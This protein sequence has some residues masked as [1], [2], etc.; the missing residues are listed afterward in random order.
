[1]AQSVRIVIDSGMAH[2][3]WQNGP[4]VWEASLSKEELEVEIE[5]HAPGSLRN[6]L[7]EAQRRLATRSPAYPFAHLHA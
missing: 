4:H 2:I 5:R 7:A 1:M 3:R 6:T